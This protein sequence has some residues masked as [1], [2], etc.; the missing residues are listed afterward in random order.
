VRSVHL[1]VPDSV[2]DPTRPSGGNVY[3]RRLCDAL[4][5]LGLDVHEHA[6]P[7]AWPHPTVASCDALAGVVARIPDA[8]VVLV[9]GLVASTV[10]DVLV[11]ETGRV[12]LVVLV[13]MPLG[14]RRADD[15]MRLRESAVLSA[16]AAIVTTS[17]WSRQ[18]LRELYGLPGDRIHVAVPGVA[19]AELAPG[20]AGGGML[21]CVA[22]VISD[23]GHDI[24]LDALA[25]IADLAW[26]CVCVGSTTRE[27]AF[28]ERL[29]RRTGELG[30]RGRVS[31]P[32]PL[33]GA[34]LDRTYATADVLVL[35]SRAETYGMV[36]AEALARGLPVVATDVG[37]VP[38]A[39]G[40]GGGDS[41]PGLLVP[42]DDA[43][44][45]ASALGMWLGNPEL[46]QRLRRA[47][48]KRRETLATWSATAS[49]MADVMAGVS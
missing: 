22:A 19:G 39:L 26:Q 1:V 38:E 44:A 8:A 32:G 12:R 3:D 33:T 17:A 37:G 11:P 43:A 18:R 4:R 24:L 14:H 23:K 7:G 10:P 45:L 20:S 35:P 28:V 21:L 47:A 49:V 13:H 6:V 16:A 40:D 42:P 9:D 48:R 5:V 29:R 34:A 41:R 46:R 2:D 27:P 15:D 25:D 36:I 31:F 30:F